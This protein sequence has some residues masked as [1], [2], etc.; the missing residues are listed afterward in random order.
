MSVKQGAFHAVVVEALGVDDVGRPV[1]EGG[2]N[3]GGVRDVADHGPQV[4]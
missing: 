2:L 1:A 4:E 3:L